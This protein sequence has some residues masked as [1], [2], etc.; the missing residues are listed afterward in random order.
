[1]SKPF[2]I[3]DLVVMQRADYWVEY[4]G[5]P[6]VVTESC[7]LREAMDMRT[8]LSRRVSTYKVKILD[9]P[10]M[11]VC[12][13]SDQLRPLLGVQPVSEAVA[14]SSDPALQGSDRTTESKAF[15]PS[16]QEGEQ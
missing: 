13:R 4:D 16:L 7:R 5:F 12:A 15:A 1:M 2:Q 10:P 3:G 8:M 14:E 11:D 6:A 9:E